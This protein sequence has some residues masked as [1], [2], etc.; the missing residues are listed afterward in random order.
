MRRR[1]NTP[2]FA[3]SDASALC[4]LVLFFIL[5]SSPGIYAQRDFFVIDSIIIEGNKRTKD[6]IILNELSF[7]EGDTMRCSI[8][9]LIDQSKAALMRRNLFTEVELSLVD[10]EEGVNQKLFVRVKELWPLYPIPKFD[11]LD[12]SYTVWISDFNASLDRV[13]YGLNLKHINLTRRGDPLNLDIVLG[14]KRSLKLEY[15]LPPLDQ[16][17]RLRSNVQ[18]EYI[19]DRDL[20]VGVTDDNEL[21]RLRDE[22]QWVKREWRY[23]GNIRYRFTNE[24]TA[25]AYFNLRHLSLS[26]TIFSLNPRYYAQDLAWH[27]TWSTS[28]IY[29][30]RSHSLF[31]EEGFRAEILYSHAGLLQSEMRSQDI[32]IDYLQSI[33]LPTNRMGIINQVKA[34]LQENQ[35]EP[36]YYFRRGLSNDL[37]SLRSYETSFILG[38]AYLF[39]KTKWY[40][41]VAD[42]SYSC[43]PSIV[44]RYVTHI[45]YK[46]YLSLNLDL[47]YI[48][49][50]KKPISELNNSMIYAIGPTIDMVFFNNFILGLDLSIN[51]DRK[52]VFNVNFDTSF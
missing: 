43:L 4:T 52:W 3:P 50:N 5:I 20:D 33:A 45:P 17:Q 38:Q 27:D 34:G 14:F 9:Y 7:K 46:I 22:D 30:T 39:N 15:E 32:K 37:S 16:K 2:Q 11:I 47:A 36:Y 8:S 1:M 29:D 25:A 13:L 49:N 24:I 48:W 23:G 44:R 19:E 6:A 51:K 35:D 42:R 18:F 21:I 31:P 40:Y 10:F 26:D 12:R 41:K 28:I